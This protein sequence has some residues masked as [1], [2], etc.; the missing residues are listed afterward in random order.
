M[1][2]WLHQNFKGAFNPNSKND[3]FEDH[4][5]RV[6][7]EKYH[8]FFKF[9]TT[10]NPYDRVLSRFLIMKENA[11]R[12]IRIS[13]PARFNFL[14]YVRW[15]EIHKDAPQFWTQIRMIESLGTGIEMCLK[16]ECI[17]QELQRL[18]FFRA[19]L[20]EFPKVKHPVY[21]P[22][23]YYCDESRQLVGYLHKRDFEVFRYS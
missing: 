6:I 19:G 1:T 18:P 9:T 2:Y 17:G 12:G 3:A 11:R 13:H 20:T 16:I 14:E 23:D 7:E 5:T 21:D 10:R 8:P 4:H 15:T 22:D